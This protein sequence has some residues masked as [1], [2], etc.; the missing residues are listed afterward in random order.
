[1]NIFIPAKHQ[2]R[3]KWFSTSLPYTTWETNIQQKSW[4]GPAF[5]RE[6][7]RIVNLEHNHLSLLSFYEYNICK[8]HHVFQC[9]L[10]SHNAL[11][12]KKQIKDKCLQTN[13]STSFKLM[14]YE[15]AWF[16]TRFCCTA[17]QNEP[18]YFPYKMCK[19][20][21]RILA[22]L[23]QSPCPFPAQTI[24]LDCDWCRGTNQLISRGF[25]QDQTAFFFSNA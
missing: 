12:N 23:E 16:S 19:E 14:F 24:D 10:F 8:H 25:L 15:F 20:V 17:W 22:R 7:R 21:W 11:Q 9:H 2:L 5:N 6:A 1:M 3:A 13:N 4:R 18:A